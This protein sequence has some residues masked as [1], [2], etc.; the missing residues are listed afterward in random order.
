MKLIRSI[1]GIRGIIGNNFNNKIASDYAKSFSSIQKNGP[2]LIGR[3]TRNQ[4]L[5]ILNTIKTEL[6]LLGRDVLDCDI[7][8][9]PAIQF[10]AEKLNTSGAIMITASHNP[11]DWNG[12]KFMERGMSFFGVPIFSVRDWQVG[13]VILLFFQ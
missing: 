2:I 13:L 1:S 3:D 8:P 10:L 5:E 12:L 11:M 4:G 7:A 6:T 9:T